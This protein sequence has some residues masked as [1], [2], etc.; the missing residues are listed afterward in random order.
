MILQG[1]DLNVSFETLNQYGINFETRYCMHFRSI[2]LVFDL[3]YNVFAMVNKLWN[4]NINICIYLDKMYI[5]YEVNNRLHETC[6]LDYLW[7][8]FFG[9]ELHDP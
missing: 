4:L 8:S 5:R 9:Y 7:F 2:D 6:I 3:I 1:Q